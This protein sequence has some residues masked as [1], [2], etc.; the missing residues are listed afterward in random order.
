MRYEETSKTTKLGT[1]VLLLGLVLPSGTPVLADPEKAGQPAA[2]GWVIPYHLDQRIASWAHR[3][4]PARQP[5]IARLRRLQRALL[6]AGGLGLREVSDRTFTAPEVFHLRQANC[7]GYAFLFVGLAREVGVP[8][9]FV[10]VEDLGKDH[11]R[12]AFNIHEEHLAAAYGSGNRVRVF[13]FGGEVGADKLRLKPV[14][15]LT[16]MALYHSNKGVESMLDGHDEAAVQW[17]RQAVDLD[18][19]LAASWINL[20][21]ALRRHGD[22]EGAQ[23][24]YEEAL[25]LE[26][27]ATS[28]ARNLAALLRTRGRLRE[29]EETLDG[30]T[31]LPGDDAFSYY[32]G[33][34][35]RSLETGDVSDAR[36]FF[37]KALELSRDSAPRR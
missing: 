14:T 25:R 11:R 2:G 15:D 37:D 21:V 27:G 20:G 3:T 5:P 31:P 30:A 13:D 26:P 9:F 18:P 6:D 36:I 12:G 4:A 24:A 19:G 22:P 32:V 23:Q 7:V 29:A 35:R 33:L 8:A 17:L 16:A 34:G 28:A 10:L 1:L